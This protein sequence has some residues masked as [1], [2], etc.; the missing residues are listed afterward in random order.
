M[1]RA[2][3]QVAICAGVFFAQPAF[4]EENGERLF[5]AKCA[6]CH[7]PDGQGKTK[8]GEKMKME[9]LTTPAK[10]K[11]LNDDKIK[12]A[13]LEGISREKDGI[14]QEMKPLKGKITDEQVAAVIAYLKTLK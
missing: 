1:R 9:S 3:W 11:E 4:A 6:P 13:I 5:K 2:I 7:G 8:Q 10:K 12:T 14:K